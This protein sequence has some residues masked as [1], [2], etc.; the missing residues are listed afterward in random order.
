[1]KSLKLKLKFVTNELK[2]KWIEKHY[3]Q[4]INLLTINRIVTALNGYEQE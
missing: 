3:M 1:M 2:E 4:E